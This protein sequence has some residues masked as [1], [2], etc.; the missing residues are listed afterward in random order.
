MQKVG[1][2]S[3]FLV[4]QAIYD[5]EHKNMSLERGCRGVYMKAAGKFGGNGGRR[6]PE[7]GLVCFNRHFYYTTRAMVDFNV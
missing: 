2:H 3:F 6:A 1:L 4:R 5:R 7:M